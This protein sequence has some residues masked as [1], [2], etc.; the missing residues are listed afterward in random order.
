M[1]IRRA[2]EADTARLVELAAQFLDSTAYG[3]LLP[4]TLEGLETLVGAVLGAGAIFVALGDGQ[5]VGMIALLACDHPI[6][7]D[8]YGDEIVWYVEPRYRDST[9]G[10]RLLREAEAWARASGLTLLKMVA[11]AHSDVGPFYARLGYTEVET[12]WAKNLVEAS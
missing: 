10:P 9:I 8:R 11:P 12:A 6:S 4:H 1:T 2:T 5:P 3:A 7:G